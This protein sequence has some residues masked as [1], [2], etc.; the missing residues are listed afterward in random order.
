MAEYV[1]HINK[2]LAV[3][4]V[5]AGIT[6][7][8]MKCVRTYLPRHWYDISNREPSRVMIIIGFSIFSLSNSK[9][10]LFGFKD[11]SLVLDMSMLLS[12][13]VHS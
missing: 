12:S 5:H 6:M 9:M 2:N 11:A 4:S 8:G 3:S 7:S 10:L 13:H 1:D